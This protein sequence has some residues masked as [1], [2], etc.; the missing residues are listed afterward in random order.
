MPETAKQ[1]DN[2][3]LSSSASAKRKSAGGRHRYVGSSADRVQT[4]P[5]IAQ[6]AQPEP[7]PIMPVGG[8]DEQK[9][10]QAKPPQA[11]PQKPQKSKK[12][13]P[14]DTTP[15]AATPAPEVGI[16]TFR[17]KQ[18][19]LVLAGLVVCSLLLGSFIFGHNVGKYRGRRERGDRSQ[20]KSTTAPKGQTEQARMAPRTPA[21]RTIQIGASGR[22]SAAQ[23][24]TPSPPAPAAAAEVWTLCVISYT[25]SHQD[26]A[27]ALR[28][29][30]SEAIPGHRV[31]IKRTGTKR[32]VCV[33]H[34]TSSNDATLTQLRDAIR[35]MTYDGKRQFKD[36]YPAKLQG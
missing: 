12:E 7:M 32:T 3:N 36:C 8:L 13:P 9:P 11:K 21:Q 10:P 16:I 18:E 27:E 4:T 1:K 23:R 5:A 24:P 20:A 35:K 2:E 29:I 17:V 30:L 25:A 31:F 26:R 6:S 14:A 28:N 33:G 34:F 19:T 15:K 22:P